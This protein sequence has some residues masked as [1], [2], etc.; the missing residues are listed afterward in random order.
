MIKKV[1][2]IIVSIL[3]F[4][5]AFFVAKTPEVNLTGAFLDKNSNLVKLTNL[6]SN[7]LTVIFEAEN[8]E[9]LDEG[10]GRSVR[11]VARKSQLPQGGRM[12]RPF[13]PRRPSPARAAASRS[14]RG[15]LSTSGTNLWKGWRASRAAHTGAS[16]RARAVW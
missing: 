12:T 7:Y 1:L 16:R 13:F 15:E 6:S 14:G 4:I 9:D 5:A 11:T 2:F 3:I 8:K 10:R